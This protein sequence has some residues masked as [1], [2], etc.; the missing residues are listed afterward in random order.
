MV[1]V[2]WHTKSSPIRKAINKTCRKRTGAPKSSAFPHRWAGLASH[3][4]STGSSTSPCPFPE[5]SS[6]RSHGIT[7]PPHW[8]PPRPSRPH[9][10]FDR[11]LAGLLAVVDRGSPLWPP[12]L[13]ENPTYSVP[14]I[15]VLGRFDEK[16]K[17]PKMRVKQTNARVTVTAASATASDQT[18]RSCL[19]EGVVHS[20]PK[21]ALQIFHSP[22]RSSIDRS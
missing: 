6:P 1:S 4:G 15:T 10:S 13:G 2:F 17:R 5:P 19:G 9:R 21:T 12:N 18:R 7:P 3:T 14:G 20:G 8:K 22:D 16:R 11:P